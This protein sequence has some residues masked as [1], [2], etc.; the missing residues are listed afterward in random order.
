M[1]VLNDSFSGATAPEAADT[2]F[3]FA[4]SG[5][6]WTMNADWYTV[7]PG[8]AGHERDMK[9]AL[10]SG[11]AR[12]LHVYAA[13]IGGVLGRGYFPKGYNNGRDI[14]DGIVILDESM[15]GGTAGKYSEGD[16]LTHEVGHRLMLEHTFAHGCSASG[17]WVVDTPPEA[18][19]Q[20]DCPWRRHL[21]RPGPRPDPQ[22][23]GLLVREHVHGGPG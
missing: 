5:I 10:Y 20:F 7:V 2:S 8:K 11:D 22:L 23:H 21:C 15:P 19:P 17:D 3:R 18:H 6:T 13:N 9:R 12:T 16:T 4:L 14:I 1:Q